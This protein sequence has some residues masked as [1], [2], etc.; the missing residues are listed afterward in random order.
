MIHSFVRSASRAGIT[1]VRNPRF[2]AWSAAAQPAGF[3]DAIRVA[4]PV[5]PQREVKDLERRRTDVVF[6][7]PPDRLQGLET[8]FPSLVHP[9]PI[10]NVVYLFLN[11][12]LPPFTSVAAR[13]AVAYAIDRARM[14]RLVAGSPLAGMPT[15]QILPPS[16][17]GYKPYCPCTLDPGPG[18]TWTAPDLQTAR[19][20]VRRSGTAGARVALAPF[21]GASGKA[22]TAYLVS[23]M[24][25][26]GYQP[27]VRRAPGPPGYFGYVANSDHHLQ[28]GIYGWI[29]DYADPY[30]FLGQLFTCASFQ[31]HSPNN[32]NVSEYC[33]PGFDRVVRRA[34]VAASSDPAA[35]AAD[36]HAADRWLVDYAAAVPVLNNIAD[37]LIAARVGNY[38]HNPQFGV[39]IDQLWVK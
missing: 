18:G 16:I 10:G 24:R 27:S 37:D 30:D 21:G 4:F 2:R 31:P 23:L 35:A 38:Q 34:T 32:F 5:P 7:P 9:Y 11:T 12:R 33:D 39:L 1:L 17:M 36:W 14:V 19:R 3:P 26:L 22:T 25:S 15:C 28:A 13:R 29:Q 20:L 8:R 6:S